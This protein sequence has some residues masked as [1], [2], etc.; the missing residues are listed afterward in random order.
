M[1]VGD[2]LR[3]SHAV[4]PSNVRS[5]TVRIGWFLATDN[6]NMQDAVMNLLEQSEGSIQSVGLIGGALT[7]FNGTKV[8]FRS[9]SHL[10]FLA[11]EHQHQNI[12]IGA[13]LT[14]FEMWSLMRVDTLVVTEDSPLGDVVRLHNP[15]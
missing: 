11:S 6:A 5:N 12:D 9:G 4:L 10:T 7:A 8:L 3:C 13:K 15:N 14:M 2:F 1:S